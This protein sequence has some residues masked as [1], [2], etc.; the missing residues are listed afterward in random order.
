MQITQTGKSVALMLSKGFLTLSLA[1]A[2]TSVT[3]L[4]VAP[5]VSAYIGVNNSMAAYAQYPAT[6]VFPDLPNYFIRIHPST[7]E[8]AITHYEPRDVAV[9]AG[10]TVIWYNDDVF[11]PHTVTSGGPGDPDSGSL[12]DSG[13]I[14][15]SEQYQLTF[16]SSSGLVGEFPYYCTL[17]PWITG[18]ISADDTVV[19]GQSFEFKSGTGS[20]LNITKYSRTLLTFTPANFE[21]AD[22]TR[23]TKFYNF[24]ISRSSDNQ[25]L[26]SGLFDAQTRGLAVELINFAG[27]GQSGIGSQPATFQLQ[28]GT[29]EIAGNLFSEPGNY[30][31]GVELV[32]VGASP[33]AQQMRDEFQIQAVS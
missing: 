14:Q 29:Y 27:A 1:V 10:T 26:F 4:T 22:D 9:P 33:P 6:T 12:F 31:L 23:L 24:S 5:M 7:F 11:V 28:G 32:G 15:T 21:G 3:G 13:E 2:L 8:G 17:H 30:T 25:T 19:T 18:F 16:D 20:T